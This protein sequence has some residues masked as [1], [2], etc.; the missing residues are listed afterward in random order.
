VTD[1]VKDVH[2]LAL[3]LDPRPSMRILV[4][5][6]GLLG[7]TTDFTLGNIDA[8]KAAQRA[9]K[10]VA[11]GV[12]VEGKATEQ[13][14]HALCKALLIFLEVCETLTQLIRT[15]T[16]S[17]FSKKYVYEA[18]VRNYNNRGTFNIHIA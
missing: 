10:D 8:L 3:F 7:H 11:R 13:V 16:F 2:F 14:S 4:R 12:T 15:V 6:K 17:T 9:W 18:T 1:G 5:E